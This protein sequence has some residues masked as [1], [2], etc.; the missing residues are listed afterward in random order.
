MFQWAASLGQGRYSFVAKGD[1]DD[2]INPFQVGPLENL[3]PGLR[4]LLI[5][6]SRTSYPVWPVRPV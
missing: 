1:D 6:P 3:Q 4:R 5:I 2:V